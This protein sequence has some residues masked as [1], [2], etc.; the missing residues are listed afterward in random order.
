MIHY[1]EYKNLVGNVS[2]IFQGTMTIT[3]LTKI[4]LPEKHMSDFNLSIE[5]LHHPPST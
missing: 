4:I 2:G 1:T 3:E 5:K